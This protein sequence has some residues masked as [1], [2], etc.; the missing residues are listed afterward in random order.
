MEILGKRCDLL[1]F[2]EG[3]RLKNKKS[4]IFLKLKQFPCS[5]RILLTGTPLQNN[6][7]EL[8][9][10]LSI[11]NPTLFESE[12]IFLNVFQKPIIS[13]MAKNST[14]EQKEV[15]LARTKELAARIKGFS[16]R[17]NADVLERYLP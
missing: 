14:K 7:A 10:C 2:D 5:K 16:L 9:T 11:V 4:K 12:N 6:L 1:I 17:R 3:H 13:G 15:A 8:Y